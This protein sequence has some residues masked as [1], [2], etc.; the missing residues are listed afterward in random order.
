MI[1]VSIQDLLDFAKRQNQESGVNMNQS[2][3]PPLSKTRGCLMVQYGRY[4]FSDRKNFKYPD[5][6]NPKKEIF[7]L[8]FYC[9]EKYWYEHSQIEPMYLDAPFAELEESIWNIGF[10]MKTYSFQEVVEILE[11]FLNKIR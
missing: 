11:N 8:K 3:S 5:P 9:G 10:K 2:I 4:K 1:T 6:T 7:G